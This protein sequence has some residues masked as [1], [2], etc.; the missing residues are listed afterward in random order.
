MTSPSS[1]P[2]P[3]T[4]QLPPRRLSQLWFAE[5]LSRKKETATYSL[6][7]LA[8][9]RLLWITQVQRRRLKG[10][11]NLVA[12]QLVVW[13][14]FWPTALVCLQTGV[15]WADGVVVKSGLDRPSELQAEGKMERPE[16]DGDERRDS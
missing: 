9:A 13:A 15:K 10:P 14:I 2:V 5:K 6:L 8:T 4:A 12:P 16:V 1:Q 11:M 3:Q 7:T